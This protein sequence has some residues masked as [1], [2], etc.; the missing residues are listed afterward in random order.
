[1]SR[2]DIA[3]ALA[4]AGVS[5]HEAMPNTITAGQGWPEWVSTTYTETVGGCQPAQTEWVVWVVL[6]PY[7]TAAEAD[8]IRDT[9]A[10]RLGAI[11]AVDQ[12]RPALITVTDGG[13]NTIPAIQYQIRT[14][15]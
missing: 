10:D 2:A 5:G 1:V 3:D 6:P 12:S 11:S 15:P 14:T 8:T 13:G 7:N 4:G 9:I